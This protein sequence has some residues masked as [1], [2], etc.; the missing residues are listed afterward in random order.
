MAQ[1]MEKN[2]VRNMYGNLDPR[3]WTEKLKAVFREEELVQNLNVL[4][5]MFAPIHPSRNK[6]LAR[7]VFR[8]T[9]PTQWLTLI[10]ERYKDIIPRQINYSEIQDPAQEGQVQGGPEQEEPVQGGPEQEE[11]VQGG[12]EQEEPVQGGP[13]QEEPVQGGP[14]QEEPVQGGPE[15]EEPVQ[16]KPVIEN[17]WNVKGIANICSRLS[18]QSAEFSEY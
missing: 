2:R 18:H 14:E 13:E 11:P 12:A 9:N 6:I 8:P 5:K 3:Q 7:M 16:D 1:Q 15:H 4:F 10:E 17:Q